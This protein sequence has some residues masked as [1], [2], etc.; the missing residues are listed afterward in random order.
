MKRIKGIPVG[1]AVAVSWRDHSGPME[2]WVMTVNAP[3]AATILKMQ[4]VG[5][6][7]GTNAGGAIISHTLAEG[8]VALINPL[9]IGWDMLDELTIL[10]GKY[11]AEKMEKRA[12]KNEK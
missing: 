2:P 5:F 9:C 12:I 4:T 1:T 7:V 6:L 3:F 10:P 11:H 8:G